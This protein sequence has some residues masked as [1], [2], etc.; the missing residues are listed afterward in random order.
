MKNNRLELSNSIGFVDF[1]CDLWNAFLAPGK[2]IPALKYQWHQ[3]RTQ[4]PQSQACFSCFILSDSSFS[5]VPKHTAKVL[6]KAKH[7]MINKSQDKQAVVYNFKKLSTPT[8][9]WFNDFFIFIPIWGK[10]PIL[11]SIFFKWVGKNHQLAKLSRGPSPMECTSHAMHRAGGHAMEGCT[12]SF[13]AWI[14]VSVAKGWCCVVV[15]FR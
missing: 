4:T 3:H 8:R 7:N 12:D 1:Y 15:C 11:T 14:F 13:R 10:I 9:W 2:G 5:P 6:W